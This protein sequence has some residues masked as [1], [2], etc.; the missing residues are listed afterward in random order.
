MHIFH[1]TEF[2]FQNSL[3]NEFCSAHFSHKSFFPEKT[4]KKGFQK[5]EGGVGGGGD[6]P[7]MRVLGYIP[8][9]RVPNCPV[10]KR[11]STQ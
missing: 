10:P 2:F 4:R 6:P 9:V 11:P 8:N 3:K 7:K 5:F 1:K